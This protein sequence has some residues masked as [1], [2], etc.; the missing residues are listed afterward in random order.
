MDALSVRRL[1][2]VAEEYVV[3]WPEVLPE[4]ARCEGMAEAGAVVGKG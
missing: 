3:G 2:A 1:F 4:G